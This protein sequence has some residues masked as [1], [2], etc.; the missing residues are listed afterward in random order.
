MP[1]PTKDSIVIIGLM[2]NFPEGLYCSFEIIS[3]S[4][5]KFSPRYHNENEL[6]NP[7]QFFTDDGI[8]A[9]SDKISTN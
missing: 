5:E 2:Y 3:K 8:F 9:P 6:R 7:I 4:N 1:C